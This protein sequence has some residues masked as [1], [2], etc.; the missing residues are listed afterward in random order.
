MGPTLLLLAA[1]EA[2]I[3]WT[4]ADLQEYRQANFQ[5]QWNIKKFIWKYAL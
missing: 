5:E 2:G 4:N 1:L 3:T